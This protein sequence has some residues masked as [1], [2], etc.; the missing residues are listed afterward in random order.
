M[1]EASARGLGAYVASD[2]TEL[3]YFTSR[4]TFGPAGVEQVH[5]LGQLSSYE[6]Q[7]LRE[8]VGQLKA[9]IEAGISDEVTLHSKL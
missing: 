6:Q 4:V 1:E 2:V 9:E 3:P 8:V 5:P 7:R